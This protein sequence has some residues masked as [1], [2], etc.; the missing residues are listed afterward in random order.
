MRNRFGSKTVNP[1]FTLVITREQYAT[2]TKVHLYEEQ[3]D[4]RLLYE[5][6]TD[7]NK[8]VRRIQELV[9]LGLVVYVPD[10]EGGE[11][12]ILYRLT[13][14]GSLV[15]QLLDSALD[16]LSSVASLQLP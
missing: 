15:L 9:E 1:I 13:Y 14:Q 16:G 12:D 3:G 4:Q 6:V 2:L 8:A 10:I 11:P 5:H 7:I